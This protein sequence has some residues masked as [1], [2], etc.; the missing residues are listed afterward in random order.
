M[1]LNFTIVV[2][3][4]GEPKIITSAD[5]EIWAQEASAVGPSLEWFPSLLGQA[6]DDILDAKA[7]AERQDDAEILAARELVFGAAEPVKNDVWPFDNG[8]FFIF[9]LGGGK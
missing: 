3:D 1:S 7:L 5:L 9:N 8:D 4:A 6:L 2:D